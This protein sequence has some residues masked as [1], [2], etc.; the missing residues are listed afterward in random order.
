MT[1]LELKSAVEVEL[2]Y[3]VP[4]AIAEQVNEGV[5]SIIESNL[6]DIKKHEIL[7]RTENKLEIDSAVA[8]AG[9]VAAKDEKGVSILAVESK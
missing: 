3:R 4:A 1:N 9:L 7:T 5:K 8:E 6:R 2:T